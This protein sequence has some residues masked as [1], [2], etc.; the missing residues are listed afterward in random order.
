MDIFCVSF[1][2]FQV[3]INNSPVTFQAIA[4]AAPS[5]SHSSRAPPS[6]NPNVYLRPSVLPFRPWELE[7]RPAASNNNHHR[8]PWRAHQNWKPNACHPYWLC[9]RQL[10]RSETTLFW[11]CPRRHPVRPL[12][13]CV[14]LWVPDPTTRD[15]I[16][17]KSCRIFSWAVCATPPVRTF[18]THTASRRLLTYRRRVRTTSRTPSSTN[19]SRCLTIVMPIC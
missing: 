17:S 9:P 7:P 4:W 12:C 18:W 8:S 1:I 10:D 15:P 13:K 6:W 5:I 11:T 2:Y 16:R 3:V 14:V 19:T